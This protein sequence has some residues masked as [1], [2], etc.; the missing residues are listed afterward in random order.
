VAALFLLLLSY[1]T[2]AQ[3]RDIGELARV[4]AGLDGASADVPIKGD[5]GQ[6]YRDT[7]NASWLAYQK[8]VAKP[9]TAW[10]RTE[11][12]FPGGNTVFYPFS[13][14][15]LVTVAHLFPNAER[16]VLVHTGRTGTCRSTY[17]VER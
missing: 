4:Y 14:P 15:D 5:P 2:L 1:P 6:A 3:P 17:I 16:Y 8:R 9:M 11:V 7:V 10:A 12:A 13:G